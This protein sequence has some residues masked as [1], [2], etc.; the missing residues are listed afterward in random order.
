MTEAAAHRH[1]VIVGASLAGTRTAQS[2]RTLGHTGPITLIGAEA[3]LPYDRPPLSKSLLKGEWSQASVDEIRLAGPAEFAELAVELRLGAAAVGLDTA[4]RSVRLGDGTTVPYDVLVIATGAAARP[5]PWLPEGVHQLRTLD[6][7][8][9]IAARLA[10]GEPVVVVGGG[11]IGT[12]IAAAARGYGC[13]VTI[14]DPV[15]E[16]MARL[17]GPEIAGGLVDL[18]R[19]NGTETRFGAGVVGIEGTPGELTVEL[20]NGERLPASTVVVGIGSVPSTGW[21]AGSGLNLDN[22]VATDG[23][24]RALGADDVYAVG[25]VAHWPHPGRGHGVRAEHWT[26]ASDQA[27]YVAEAITKGLQDAYEPTDYVWSDQ[28]DWKV[29][30]FGRR[31]P[32]GTSLVI[33]DLAEN[34]KVAVIHATATGAA[35]GAVT[36]N[37]VRALNQARRLLPAATPAQDI[38]NAIQKLL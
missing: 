10:L 20:D 1:V 26:N 22:G 36:V 25:D 12:E 15:P 21:L 2:L 11:F 33:G 19:R 38:A 9:S 13:A 6:D 8:R 24:L 3:E 31:D 18:H 28:Y 29:N 14:V 35:C 23:F 30:A 16:P 37:W 34:G 17:V 5:S 32:E 4:A 27:R 7:A